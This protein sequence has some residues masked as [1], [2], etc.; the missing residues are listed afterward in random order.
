VAAAVNFSPTI[1]KIR[2]WVRRVIKIAGRY[3]GLLELLAD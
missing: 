2:V 3:G 1:K